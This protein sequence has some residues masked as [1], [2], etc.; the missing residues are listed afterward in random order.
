MADAT[1]SEREE[2]GAWV[3]E[4]DGDIRGHGVWILIMGARNHPGGVRVM[5]DDF[6]FDE[7]HTEHVGELVRRV[8]TGDARVTAKRAFLAE[9]LVLQVQAGSTAYSASTEGDSADDLSAWGR[10]LAAP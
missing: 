7:V 2:G 10:L 9:R 5:L 1:P 6:T 8:F 3:A 4:W